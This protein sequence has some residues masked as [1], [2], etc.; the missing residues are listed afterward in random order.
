MKKYRSYFILATVLAIAS[1]AGCKKK[2]NTVSP[3]DIASFSAT[4]QSGY[5]V[6][7]KGTIWVTSTSLASGNYTV[8]YHYRGLTDST[9]IAGQ[10]ASM[11]FANHGGTF[12]TPVLSDSSATYFTLDSII[13]SI[14]EVS[15]LTAG[16]LV[17]MADSTGLMTA[18][19]GGNPF[20]SLHPV[21]TANGPEMY[22]NATYY[23]PGSTDHQELQFAVINDYTAPFTY[24]FSA[25]YVTGGA[26]LTDYTTGGV[27]TREVSYGTVILTEATP[28]VVGSFSMTCVDSTRITGTFTCHSP[29]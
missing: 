17:T 18:S 29:Y 14:G 23:A 24:T 8:L 4:A 13:N 28:M 1:F 16:N 2:S 11:V 12:Q 9:I 3:P 7:A 10:S 25:P 20:I 19:V 26:E 27:V 22:I 5:T 21:A 6:G 15:V